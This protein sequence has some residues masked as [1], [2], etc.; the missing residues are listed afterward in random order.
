MLSS[1]CHKPYSLKHK[2]K[3]LNEHLFELDEGQEA[4]QT[5]VFVE[6]HAFSELLSHVD[7]RLL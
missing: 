6:P 4:L 1:F 3:Y 7:H 2:K 5:H